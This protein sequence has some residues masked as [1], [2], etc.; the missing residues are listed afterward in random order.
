MCLQINVDPTIESIEYSLQCR[1][2]GQSA[3]IL[4]YGNSSNTGD[5]EHR[6]LNGQHKRILFV[7]LSIL[8]MRDSQ[9]G[10]KIKEVKTIQL[11]LRQRLFSKAPLGET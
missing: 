7:L 8:I 4:K 9:P 3:C 1:K 10:M 11:H 6:G 2:N 5:T